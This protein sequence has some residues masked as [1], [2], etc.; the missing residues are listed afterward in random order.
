ITNLIRGKIQI[1]MAELSQS[2]PRTA[3]TPL[4]AKVLPDV[5]LAKDATNIVKYMNQENNLDEKLAYEAWLLCTDGSFAEYWRFVRDLK[6][7]IEEYQ[8]EDGQNEVE[9]APNRAVC[10]TCGYT[11]PADT[12]EAAVPVCPDCGAPMGPE[13]FKARE[14]VMQPNMVTKTRP[15]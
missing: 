14:T 9:L 6:F 2:P 1:V 3:F 4:H 13:S 7:G 8:V 10:A 12:P 15:A 11:E 5:R